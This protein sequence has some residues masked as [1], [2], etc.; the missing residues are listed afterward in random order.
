V[1]SRTTWERL[2]G[3]GSADCEVGVVM[4]RIRWGLL[5]LE[6]RIVARHNRV[7]ST[8]RIDFV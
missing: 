3:E 2:G 4:C 6:R 1:D 7:Q 8:V 5:A